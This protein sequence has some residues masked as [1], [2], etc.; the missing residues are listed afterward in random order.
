MLPFP[1]MQYSDSINAAVNYADREKLRE[2]GQFWTPEWVAKAMALYVVQNNP[3]IILDPAVGEGA[4]L[5]ALKDVYHGPVVAFDIDISKVEHCKKF[6]QHFHKLDLINEDFMFSESVKYPAIISNPPYIRHH[7]LSRELKHYLLQFAYKHTNI[8][9]DGRTGYHA[10]FLIQSLQLLDTD[11][12]LC[13][14]LPG[15]IFEGLSANQLWQWVSNNY[16]IEAVLN[17]DSKA[18]P[19]PT[20][21]INAVVVFIKRSIKKEY[22]IW[23]KCFNSDFPIADW[24]ASGF[25]LLVDDRFYTEAVAVDKAINVGLSRQPIE[26][27]PDVLLGKYFGVMRGIATG[28]NAYF[29]FDKKKKERH[30]IPDSYFVRV[31][32]RTRDL[33]SD[34]VTDQDLEYLDSKGIPT[35]LLS[36]G[37]EHFT[38]FPI[39]LQ[40]YLTLGEELGLPDRSL[41]SMR[42]PWYKMEKRLI[43]DYLFAYL[44][45][46]NVRFIKNESLAVPLTSFLCIYKKKGYDIDHEKLILSPGI[47]KYLPYVAKS[48]GG[49]ALK[50][51][52]RSLTRLPIELPQNLIGSIP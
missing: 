35:Y 29:L 19:F 51:E 34:K 1:K 14:I 27:L 13:F 20:V 8:V 5:T 7:R 45:R 52:P 18:T 16:C 46:R 23:G 9:F 48:Y 50:V 11:G 49:G 31:I 40:K 47:L 2:K 41:I 37:R 10:Y 21:D 36:L 17:F 39:S 6:T 33:Q 43:P 44:G 4:L 3:S 24:V 15:D 32:G 25:K 26:A 42:N 38:S 28:D 30:G 12:H 22:L